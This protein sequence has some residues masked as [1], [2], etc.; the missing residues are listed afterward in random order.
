MQKSPFKNPV[1]VLLSV[2]VLSVFGAFLRWLQ[3]S[4]SFE[5]DTGFHIPGSAVT[6][7]F[8]IYCA[9]AA[10]AIVIYV[11]FISRKFELPGAPESAFFSES[12]VPR[13]ISWAATIVTV[14]ASIII[15][16][17][18]NTSDFPTLR[19][20]FGAGGIF[21]GLSYTSYFAARKGSRADGW[22]T[23]IPTIFSFI[24]LICGYKYNSHNPVVWAYSI[25]ILA[26]CASAAAFLYLSAYFYGRAKP[27]AALLFSLAA[28]FFNI[29]TLADGHSV[30]DS[31]IFAGAAVI[32]LTAAFLIVGNTG[33]KKAV[34]G[35]YA[36]GGETA[37]ED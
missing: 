29:T 13:F 10:A 19:R 16:I 27:A 2:L 36:E 24:W 33:D 1:V 34:S 4:T 17:Q 6:T 22:E 5:A 25:E 26:I 28:S 7:I 9:V 12:A 23:I 21:L 8:L 32:F 30:C 14:I 15:M 3:N 37:P 31:A 11:L 35:K 18:S 20:I